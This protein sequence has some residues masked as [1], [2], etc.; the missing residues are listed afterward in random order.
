MTYRERLEQALAPQGFGHYGLPE[1]CAVCGHPASVGDE[2]FLF[3][4][5]PA[6]RAYGWWHKRCLPASLALML[7]EATRVEEDDE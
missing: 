5:W 7:A 1:T 2:R 4:E 3:M 6:E